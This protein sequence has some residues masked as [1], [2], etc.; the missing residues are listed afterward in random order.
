VNVA[1]RKSLADRLLARLDA[2][3]AALTLA[4]EELL[5]E[6]GAKKESDVTHLAPTTFVRKPDVD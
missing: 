6:L 2:R 3:I 5:A 4:R 1:K